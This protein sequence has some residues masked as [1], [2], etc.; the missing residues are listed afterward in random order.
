MEQDLILSVA[1]Q[2]QPFT[3]IK[4]W[5]YKARAGEW[6]GILH[7]ELRRE[8]AERYQKGHQM[9]WSG[10]SSVVFRQNCCLDLLICVAACFR[11]LF[12]CASALCV[13]SKPLLF[14]LLGP[15]HNVLCLYWPVLDV[16]RTLL[17]YLGAVTSLLGCKW[18]SY[19][20]FI[21]LNSDFEGVELQNPKAKVPRAQAVITC[22]GDSGHEDCIGMQRV[23][24]QIFLLPPDW[25][26]N[27]M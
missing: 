4:P 20:Y 15:H 23:T 8:P 18:M 5:E 12:Q 25:I 7:R 24:P 3:V 6:A 1:L 14:L 22:R 13:T 17:K 2:F 10:T 27:W 19:T 26:Q 11:S 16:C 21:S 9:W